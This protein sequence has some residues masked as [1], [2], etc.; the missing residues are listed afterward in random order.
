MALFRNSQWAL[1]ISIKKKQNIFK[2][3][4]YCCPQQR[5]SVKKWISLLHVSHPRWYLAPLEIIFLFLFMRFS[6]WFLTKLVDGPL[7]ILVTSSNQ[8]PMRELQYSRDKSREVPMRIGKR[9]E[10]M[11]YMRHFLSCEVMIKSFRPDLLH[12]ISILMFGHRNIVESGS[13]WGLF[14]NFL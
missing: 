5:N 2:H 11:I 8:V 7:I 10:Y 6:V 1:W 3:I 13:L 9:G 12:K 4:F 14:S